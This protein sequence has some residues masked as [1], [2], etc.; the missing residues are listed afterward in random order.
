M[1]P[2]LT[3]QAG[4]QMGEAMRS[5]RVSSPRD[6]RGGAVVKM[7]K[8]PGSTQVETGPGYSKNRDP[9]QTLGKMNDISTSS[10]QSKVAGK[11]N[12]QTR[13]PSPTPE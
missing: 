7:E 2:R 5:Q 8:L 6:S 9:T 10:R 11:N 1:I 12:A 3:A 13:H 4:E